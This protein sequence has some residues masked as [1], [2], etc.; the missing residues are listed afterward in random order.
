MERRR[1]GG[2]TDEELDRLAERLTRKDNSC[3]LTAE[4][5]LAVVDIINMK[6]KGV[7]LILYAVGLLL[8][9]ILKDVYQFIQAH[10]DWAKNN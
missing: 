7:K 6:K 10:I 1:Q 9:W 2:L 8:L 3:R 5:Q 4:Q